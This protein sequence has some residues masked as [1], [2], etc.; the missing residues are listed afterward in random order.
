MCRVRLAL[1]ISVSV[2]RFQKSIRCNS[3]HGTESR[4][5]PELLLFPFVCFETSDLRSTDLLCGKA[6]G[7][8]TF[9][10]QQTFIYDYPICGVKSGAAQ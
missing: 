3:K 8:S 4:T 1:L 2:S 10:R 7:S 9:K 5:N 6:T